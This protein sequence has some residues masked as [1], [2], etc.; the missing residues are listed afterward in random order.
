MD[1]ALALSVLVRPSSP[2]MEDFTATVALWLKLDAEINRLMLALRERRSI[3]RRLTETILSFMTG[4][5]I[6]DLDTLECRLSCRVR[7]VR[8]PL[9]H[10]LIQE[11][12]VS[13]YSG[14]SDTAQ[15][16]TDAVFSR[17]RVD[18]VSLRRRAIG[19]Q[20]VNP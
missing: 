13:L 15:A 16:V 4:F 12:L 1:Q 7:Q 9:P 19:P 20:A 6:D 10:R 8:A 18:R 3:K 5:G 11:R 14:D 2:Q 17:D